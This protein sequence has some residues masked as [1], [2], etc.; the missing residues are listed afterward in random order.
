MRK[1]MG[2]LLVGLVALLAVGPA[3]SQNT[4]GLVVTGCGTVTNP[5]TA[6]RP[7]P[8]TVDTAGY[9]C[10]IFGTT[11]VT[12]GGLSRS[13]VVLANSTNATSVK[14]SAGQVYSIQVFNNSTNIAYLK[15]YDKASAP[16]CNSDTVVWN[17]LIPASANGAGAVV[18]IDVGL[19]FTTGIAYCVTGG[20][21][22]SDNTAVAATSFIVNVGYK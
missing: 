6:G 22:A 7:G 19:T 10:G 17:V 4:T 9:L 20:I 14:A 5:F 16:T 8:F 3:H 13:S 12:S 1:L 11:P 21:A 2:L 15:F 18:P